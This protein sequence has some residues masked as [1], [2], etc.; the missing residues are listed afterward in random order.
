MGQCAACAPLEAGDGQKR[1]LTSTHA[2]D[3][4]LSRTEYVFATQLQQLAQARPSSPPF[5]DAPSPAKAALSG[6]RK[7]WRVRSAP[8]GHLGSIGLP[9]LVARILELRGVRN[10]QEAEVFLGGREELPSD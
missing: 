9:E 6:G 5:G 10:R 8:P 7:R 3:T 4:A 1:W 2:L